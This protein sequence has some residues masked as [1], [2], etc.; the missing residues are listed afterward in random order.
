MYP[1]ISHQI[2]KNHNIDDIINKKTECIINETFQD[3]PLLIELDNIQKFLETKQK[4]FLIIHFDLKF[5]LLFKYIENIKMNCQKS[6][7]LEIV[8][9]SLQ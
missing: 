5:P 8:T 1:I 9:Y 7:K 6:Q 2:K 3:I 4:S